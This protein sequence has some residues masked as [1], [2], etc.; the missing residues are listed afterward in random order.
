MK[1]PRE[2]AFLHVF[3]IVGVYHK[4]IDTAIKHGSRRVYLVGFR[5]RSRRWLWWRVVKI[6]CENRSAAVLVESNSH[7]LGSALYALSEG[8]LP[9][10]RQLHGKNDT[11]ATNWLGVYSG[12]F[13][14]VKAGGGVHLGSSNEGC[15]PANVLLCTSWKE[16]GPLKEVVSTTGE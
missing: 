16:S 12:G 14:M 8:H 3:E 7:C 6:R 1:A 5:S 15:W 2:L 9:V 10:G 13:E 4:V 11:L